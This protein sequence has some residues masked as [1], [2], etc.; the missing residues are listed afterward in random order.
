M[1][2]PNRQL[3]LRRS[4]QLLSPDWSNSQIGFLYLSHLKSTVSPVVRNILVYLGQCVTRKNLLF[5]K[6]KWC[7]LRLQLNNV[8]HIRMVHVIRE[9][10]Q[11]CWNFFLCKESSAS[12]LFPLL[13]FVENIQYT[14]GSLRHDSSSKRLCEWSP[15]LTSKFREMS[16]PILWR[17][18]YLGACFTKALEL[19]VE[20]WVQ[21]IALMYRV[22]MSICD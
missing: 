18:K 2:A 9:S 13:P 11:R 19:K 5:A 4:T 16:S 21:N 20:I 1:E 15:H 22:Y 12:P 8:F 7:A 17:L 14:M 6:C 10:L 3:W